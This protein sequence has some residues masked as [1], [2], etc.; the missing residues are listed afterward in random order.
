MKAAVYCAGGP[1]SGLNDVIYGV[2]T[3]LERYGC[4]VIGLLDG[5]LH[6][7]L[8]EPRIKLL[9]SREVAK[10]EGKGG[11]F[12]GISRANPTKR[13]EDL[14]RVARELAKLGIDIL[15]TIGGDDTLKTAAALQR[16]FDK[17]AAEIGRRIV[18][19][20]VPK[21]IDNDLWMPFKY[22]TFGYRTAVGV[23]AADVLAMRED[24]RT[25]GDR[26]FVAISQGRSAGW[27]ALGIAKAT[28]SLVI[29]P[30]E[31]TEPVSM[32]LLVDMLV[33]ASVKRMAE[34]IL[35]SKPIAVRGAA[36]VVAEGVLDKVS[37]L[38]PL[39]DKFFPCSHDD[40]FDE[41]DNLR[42]SKIPKGTLLQFMLSDRTQ[43]LGLDKVQKS[44]GYKLDYFCPEMG[45]N[46]RCAEPI[47]ED[48]MY[49][50]RLGRNA[51]SFAAKGRCGMVLP[52]ASR[53]V[54]KGFRTL[55]DE[56]GKAKVRR[57]PLRNRDYQRLLKH[58]LSPGDVRPGSDMLMALTIA[59]GMSAKTIQSVFEQAI[60]QGVRHEL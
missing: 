30:E 11:S 40:M 12:I 32:S 15:V 3:E 21:T 37:D 23:G 24:S 55:L 5:L 43:E 28:D 53:Y 27:L 60:E 54:C 2:C 47:S 18:V 29:I 42:F 58:R 26:H 59:S 9:H 35:S 1:A 50:F 49:S 38:K 31:F 41:H 51:A 56:S 19:V 7:L 36:H 16:M 14:E 48:Q 34:A 6:F 39:L 17:L 45:W 46:A 25:T 20:H 4:Q 57:V 13:P 22:Y 44:R 10:H 52:S 33:G 8:G